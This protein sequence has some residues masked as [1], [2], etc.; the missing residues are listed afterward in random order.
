M[1]PLVFVHGFMGGSE[2]W[3]LQS[4]LGKT[5]DLIFVDLPGFGKN[6]DLPAIN[7]ISGFANWVLETLT[8]Q[9]VERFDLLGHSMGGMVVQEM[10]RQAPERVSKLVLYGTGAQGV[11]PGRFETIEKSME[12]ARAD[13][14]KATARRISATWFL[15]RESA[16]EFEACAKIAEQSTLDAILA[17][18]AAMRDWSGRDALAEISSPTLILWGN[19]DRTYQRAQIDLLVQNIPNSELVIVDNASHAVHLEKPELFNKELM[20]FLDDETCA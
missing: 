17:G 8:Q 20:R 16:N 15:E 3:A 13:G 10:M 6:A 2:Q 12:R 19:K 9:S 14:P 7:S 5:R 11:L 1:K 18:L 4:P